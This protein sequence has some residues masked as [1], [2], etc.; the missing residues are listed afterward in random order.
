MG[1]FRNNIKSLRRQLYEESSD[2][3]EDRRQDFGQ[4]GR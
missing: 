4:L 3:I 2:P 1:D